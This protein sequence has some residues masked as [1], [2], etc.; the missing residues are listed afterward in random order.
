MAAAKADQPAVPKVFDAIV[1]V[2]NVLVEAGGIGK[3]RQNKDQGYSFRGIDDMYNVL[4]KLLVAHRLCILPKV[5]DRKCFKRPTRNGSIMFNVVL[6][7]DLQF[8]SAV[9]G[10]MHTV[11]TFGEASDMADKAT[12][13]AMSAAYKYAVIQ[14]FCIPV[15]VPDAD[16]SDPPETVDPN[17]AVQAAQKPAGQIAQKP[18]GQKTAGASQQAQGGSAAPK[19]TTGGTLSAEAVAEILA[20]VGAC[21]EEKEIVSIAKKFIATA[22]PKEGLPKVS[23]ETAKELAKKIASQRAGITTADSYEDFKAMVT[24]FVDKSWLGKAE[25]EIYLSNAREN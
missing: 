8:V 2:M 15:E 6:Q 14:A 18:A 11:T 10:S 24:C 1:E 16:E 3:D 17:A 5:L 25:A 23:K 4:S 19:G 13:K 9:D 7:V 22:A 21:T 12:N 20:K